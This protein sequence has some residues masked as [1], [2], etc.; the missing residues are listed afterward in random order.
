MR[1]IRMFLVLALVAVCVLWVAAPASAQFGGLKD[2]AKKTAEDKAK[3]KAE[4]EAQKATEESGEASD[5]A[6]EAEQTG[7]ESDESNA[8]PESSTPPNASGKPG[9][10]AW[11]NYDFVPGDRV[12]FFDDFAN[13]V[14]GNF[15]QRLE[16]LRGNMEVAE[17]KGRRWLR[18]TTYSDFIVPVPEVLPPRFTL[19]FDLYAPFNWNVLEVSGAMPEADDATQYTE[20]CV[21][22]YGSRAGVKNLSSKEE[23]S[24][25][26]F[27]EQVIQGVMHCRVMADGKYM[28]M[29][30]N[31]NR[32]ANFPNANF[33]RS[34][35][36]LFVIA[37]DPEYPLMLTDIRVAASDKKMYDALVSAGRVA[38]QGIFFDSGSDRIRPESTPTLKEIGQ[39]LTEHADLRL[40]IEGHTDSQGD[41]A[42]NQD[43]SERRASAVRGYLVN[44][45]K[46]ADNRLDAKGFGES[47]PVSSND[48]AEGRQNNRRVELVK[49]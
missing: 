20:V 46:I 1:A 39:M 17:W 23:I 30:V 5:Q 27:P 24:V 28:K 21:S 42:S 19:E 12:I 40:L 37:A 3:Q 38:T 34:D 31:E 4:E 13:D 6:E 41:D 25:T 43:L 14:V 2:K 49:I 45:Y 9:E 16:L 15:P 18:T 11:V 48:T 44:E 47:K 8:A 22:P 26:K 7:D 10:G 32:V 33:L 36:L 35:R 29:Y